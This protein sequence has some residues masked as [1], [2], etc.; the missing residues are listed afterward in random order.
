MTAWMR[1]DRVSISISISK[2]IES[3]T[4]LML[5]PQ[6]PERTASI[7]WRTGSIAKAI[8]SSVIWTGKAIGSKLIW[9]A[10]VIGSNTDWTV[11]AT[12][13]I[14]DSIIE[15]IVTNENGYEDKA[16]VRLNLPGPFFMRV[17]TDLG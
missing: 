3:M 12:G 8:E 4:G 17:A 1:E 15:A 7:S 9:I 5:E 16:L 11:A 14:A 2:A 6:E 10:E 13:S